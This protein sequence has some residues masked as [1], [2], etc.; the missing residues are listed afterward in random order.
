M[1]SAEGLQFPTATVFVMGP[2]FETVWESA[3]GTP[4]WIVLEC[5][6]DRLIATV[7][8]FAT[9]EHSLTAMESVEDQLFLTAKEFVEDQPQRYCSCVFSIY[10]F[11]FNSPL[12]PPYLNSI[13]HF[14]D[15]A[16]VCNGN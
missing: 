15:C 11:F 8:M 12:F 7:Q 4:S 13:L 1:G 3:T 10:I 6:E 9:V 16:G 14:Q 2:Q 5:V